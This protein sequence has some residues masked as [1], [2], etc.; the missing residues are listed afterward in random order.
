[1]GALWPVL[2]CKGPHTHVCGHPRLLVLTLCTWPKIDTLDCPVMSRSLHTCTGQPSEGLDQE[3][4]PHRS[5]KQ[6]WTTLT[7]DCGISSM[8]P[9]MWEEFWAGSSFGSKPTLRD[10]NAFSSHLIAEGHQEECWLA[11]ELDLQ[12]W[13]LLTSSPVLGIYVLP[14]SP[15][16]A[17]VLG[18]SLERV[19]HC[20]D[21]LDWICDWT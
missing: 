8:W 20:W 16:S 3:P 13:K 1:M 14:L 11:H 18:C 17:A 15:I 4:G 5:C 10:K 6:A 12:N 9:G 19:R 2:S 7:G 21:H